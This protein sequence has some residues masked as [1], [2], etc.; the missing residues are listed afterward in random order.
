VQPR[1]YDSL[2]R[3]WKVEDA[4]VRDEILDLL[5]RNVT[6][7]F[8]VGQSRLV[9]GDV[10]RSYQY[11]NP[12]GDIFLTVYNPKGEPA[13]VTLKPDLKHLP[14]V[15]DR[16][17]DLFE[18]DIDDGAGLLRGAVAGAE[19]PEGIS[20][21][22]DPGEVKVVAVLP[23]ADLLVRDYLAYCKEWPILARSTTGRFVGF[24]RDGAT[25]VLRVEAVPDRRTV[26]R[27]QV[28]PEANVTVEDAQESEVT[29]SASGV[30][31]AIVHSD[32]PARIMLRR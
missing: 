24:E 12:Q 4:Q 18:W 25:A 29:R 31:V 2:T 23:G 32:S 21:E 13:R 17:Y 7:G 20:V 10:F 22:L 5:N 30:E 28:A 14:I 1:L 9:A 6:V 16:S 11:A 27:I 19:L 15:A 8:A 26:T 3:K